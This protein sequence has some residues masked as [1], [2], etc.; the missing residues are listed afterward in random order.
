[1]SM[2]TPVALVLALS[3]PVACG[4]DGAGSTGDTGGSSGPA[5]SGDDATTADPT[6]TTT[7]GDTTDAPETTDGTT[8]DEP[9]FPVGGCGLS[10]YALLDAA[11]MGEVVQHQMVLEFDAATIDALLEAQGFGALV[12][13][14]F[15]ARVYKIRYVTQ[16]RGAPVEATGFVAYPVGAGD[17]ERPV[18]AWAHGTTGFTDMCAPTAAADG[19]AVPLILSALGFVAVAPDYLGMNGWGMPSGFVHPYIV[20]EPTAIAT[21]DSIRALRRFAADTGETPPSAPSADIVLFGASEGGFA[22]LWADRY[23][24]FYAPELKIVANVA[25]VPPTDAFGLTQHGT[26]VFGPTTGA[27]AAAI[28]GGHAWHQVQQ[29]LSDVLSVGPPVDIASE[30]P[31][32]MLTTCDAGFPDTVTE[33]SHVYNQAFIDMVQAEDWE[34]LGVFGCVLKKA[35]LG[36]SE[37]P[38]QVA[39]PTL[40]IQGEAD[41]LVYTPVIRDDLPRLCDQGYVIEHFEC[42][43][44]GHTEAATSSI[45]Y[46]LEWVQARLAGEPLADPCVIHEPVDCGML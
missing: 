42:A 19:Y 13:V 4:D 5:S 39:T 7:V 26:S 34:G 1:M 21:L 18:V 33:T 23:A 11:D 44:A 32:L 45:P 24:P 6:P 20:P 10:E 29:P 14:P 30:L 9:A 27:L 31:E 43:G 16:D 28:V 25:S 8:G 15:G 35:S 22:T 36:D 40:V 41:D 46:A 3:L 2:R 38:L 37:V 12:P 17:G